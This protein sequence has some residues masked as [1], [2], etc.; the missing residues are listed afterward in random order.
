MWNLSIQPCDGLFKTGKKK[1][2]V[3]GV[4]YFLREEYSE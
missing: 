4:A 2:F 3:S 1:E